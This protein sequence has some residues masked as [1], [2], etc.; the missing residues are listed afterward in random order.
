MHIETI[1]TCESGGDLTH[2]STLTF[3]RAAPRLVPRSAQ[4]GLGTCQRYSVEAFDMR[5][6]N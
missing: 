5:R 1:V 6:L 3:F 2:F 4:V